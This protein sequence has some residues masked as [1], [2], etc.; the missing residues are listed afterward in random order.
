MT[1]NETRD[2]GFL[3][4]FAERGHRIVPSSP[5]T[6]ER[7]DAA[8]RQRGHEPVQGRVHG[9]RERRDYVRAATSQKCL[10]VSGKHN[11]LEMVGA[12]RGTTPS[13]RCW[14]TFSFGDYF[15]KNAIV[16][17]WEL[18][19][20]VYGLPAGPPLGLGLRGNRVDRG[21]RGGL[22]DLARRRGCAVGDGSSGSAPRTISGAWATPDPAVRAARSTTIW[23]R[24]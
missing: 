17:A 22:R 11:D 3:D 2:A 13:S 16:Y 18:V 9:T 6:A 20:G 12:R 4:Y 7:P 1:A 14:A 10:R 21:R 15:K 23:A 8:L 19:T 5:G 24:I